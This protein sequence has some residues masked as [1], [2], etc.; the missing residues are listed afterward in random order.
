[1]NNDTATSYE[2]GNS[3]DERIGPCKGVVTRSTDL[4]MV[5]S[6]CPITKQPVRRLVATYEGYPNWQDNNCFG[7]VSHAFQEY[8]T[9]LN[10]LPLHWTDGCYARSLPIHGDPSDLASDPPAIDEFG[11]GAR[12]AL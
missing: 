3:M 10:I 8:R 6:I 2:R 7:I 9:P 4:T 12:Y 5:D 1:M 11:E